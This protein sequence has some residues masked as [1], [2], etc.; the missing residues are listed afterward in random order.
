MHDTSFTE[1]CANEM[2]KRGADTQRSTVERQ[3]VVDLMI[4]RVMA[5]F[6]YDQVRH[7]KYTTHLVSGCDSAERMAQIIT[8]LAASC[9]FDSTGDLFL[10]MC[11]RPKLSAE[12][13]AQ[14]IWKEPP[15]HQLAKQ[16]R[17]DDTNKTVFPLIETRA[18]DRAKLVDWSTSTDP[19]DYMFAI[20][21]LCEYVQGSKLDV[22]VNTEI[23]F[24][25]PDRTH[26]FVFS[27][28]FLPFS[29]GIGIM[30]NN[31]LTVLDKSV[32][33]PI[34]TLLLH[35]ARARVS[36]SSGALGYK[37]LADCCDTPDL[38][39][40]ENPFYCKLYPAHSDNG[41]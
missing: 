24:A 2:V 18:S 33:F 3:E 6:A 9:I 11:L 16:I 20:A 8:E 31:V 14:L 22:F 38:V 29:H 36:E 13:L 25:A 32:P 27:M 30:K 17:G 39:T 19:D 4:G 21:I 28:N 5:G 37:Q 34:P 26:P 15:L 41:F 12:R 23:P 1:E 40:S 35:L 7:Y 10:H